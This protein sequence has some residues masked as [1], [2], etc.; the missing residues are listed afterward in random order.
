[1]VYISGSPAYIEVF[2][3]LIGRLILIDNH[4]R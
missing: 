3:K 4:I 2:R 1:M